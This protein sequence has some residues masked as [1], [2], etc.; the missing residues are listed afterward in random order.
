MEGIVIVVKVDESLA[1]AGDHH[2]STYCQHVKFARAVRGDSA[3]EVSFSDGIKAVRIGITAQ[4]SIR[5]GEVAR[6]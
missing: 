2:G 4:E 6:L 5:A 1:A 3:V